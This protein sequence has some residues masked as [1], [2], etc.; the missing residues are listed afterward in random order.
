MLDAPCSA[1]GTIRRHPDVA[2]LKTPKDVENLSKLQAELLDAAVKMLKPL[3]LI[4]FCTCS[5]QPEEGPQQVKKFLYRH[6]D[7]NVESIG[8]D[9]F[10]F[11]SDSSGMFRSLPSDDVEGGGWDGFFVARLRHKLGD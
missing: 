11:N 10:F 8:Q 6:P 2:H 5:L 3:G 4:L 1:T 9:E 7:F